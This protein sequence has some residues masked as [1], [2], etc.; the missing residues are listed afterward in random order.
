MKKHLL[1]VAICFMSLS[2]FAGKIKTSVK[3]GEIARGCAGKGICY[4]TTTTSNTNGEIETDWDYTGGTL[5]MIIT[6]SNAALMP[7]DIRSDL[8]NGTFIVGEDYVIAEDVR[9]A[10]GLANG[11]TV[12]AGT[13]TATHIGANYYISL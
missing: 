7:S 1:S 3:F 4:S 6:N 5:T 11:A 2:A 12:K 13:H 8:G 9:S 10:L